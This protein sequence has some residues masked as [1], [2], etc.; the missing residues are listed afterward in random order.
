[1]SEISTCKHPL[2]AFKVGKNPETGKDILKVVPY[3]VEM[4]TRMSPIEPFVYIYDKDFQ[5]CKGV[6]YRDYVEI[7][8][9]KC[10]SCRLKRSREW[11]DR[12]MLE[13]P[14]HKSSYFVTL[15]YDD[16][17]VP[18]G[19]L[20]DENG[21]LV[22]NL[23]LDKKDL[24]KFLKRLRIQYERSGHTNALKYYACG[25]YGGRS[26]HRPHFH[27][28]VFGLE[29][30]DL[31]VVC[32]SRLGFNYYSSEWL[33]KVWSLG[34]VT[35]ADVSWETCAYTARY[36]MKKHLGQDA[37]YYDE[38]CIEPEF[39]TMSLKPGIGSQYF[40]EH[41]DKIYKLDSISI[42]TS[43]GGRNIKPPKYFDKLMEADENNVDLMK[44][45]KENR[46]KVASLKKNQ[47]LSQTDRD[48]LDILEI[49]E[50]LLEQRVKSLSRKEID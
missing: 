45:I 22:E 29:L 13:L 4:I 27:I 8:C 21:F 40:D 24:Q 46:E 10:I 12:C 36:I 35:I 32:Q 9:G 5:K 15:T 37:D 18:Y 1:M 6:V 49:E 19:E 26:T 16:E 17:H 50:R 39:T 11:A 34:H 38:L 30:D 3:N 47:M 23:T 48:Y 43:K 33:N 42:P 41:K 7:P 31:Q 20:H 25:E 14:Y 44:E 28:I 2:K